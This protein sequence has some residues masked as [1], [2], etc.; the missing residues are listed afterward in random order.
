MNLG[1]AQEN[2]D[3]FPSLGPSDRFDA[4]DMPDAA[5]R[6][7]KVRIHPCY[8][9][10]LWIGV[11]RVKGCHEDVRVYS[12]MLLISSGAGHSAFPVLFGLIPFSS[13]HERWHFLAGVMTMVPFCF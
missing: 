9:V 10:S 4:H 1:T 5:A 13:F 3:A 8:R 6:W 2:R 7:A 11:V 12:Q